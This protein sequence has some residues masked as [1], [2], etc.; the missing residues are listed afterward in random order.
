MH[1]I[2]TTYY[3]KHNIPLNNL[4]YDYLAKIFFKRKF[5]D[6]HMLN[7]SK[8]QDCKLSYPSITIVQKKGYFYKVR[9][10]QLGKESV[11]INIYISN[12]F[13]DK[14]Q[15][16]PEAVQKNSQ[17]PINGFWGSWRNPWVQTFQTPLRDRHP[18]LQQLPIFHE[19]SLLKIKLGVWPE[20]LRQSGHCGV[21]YF[22]QG[23][24]Y[25]Y[26]HHLPQSLYFK[27]FC[28]RCLSTSCDVACACFSISVL[29]WTQHPGKNS[30]AGEQE[31]G[32]VSAHRLIVL[33]Q[34]T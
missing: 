16:A 20:E 10:N 8:S 2:C 19:R 29:L 26:R 17:K 24:H 11:L 30:V 33:M 1:N 12:F 27:M 13:S 34:N 15:G 25:F 23:D 32:M 14:S 3:A 6:R 28:C 21:W 9:N 7:R 5:Q 18:G 4:S 22:C 31:T